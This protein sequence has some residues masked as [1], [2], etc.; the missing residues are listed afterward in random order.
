MT[1]INMHIIACTHTH[2]STH[3]PTYTYTHQL[4]YV[5]SKWLFFSLVCFVISLASLERICYISN[6]FI[7]KAHPWLK[8]KKA[9][10]RNHHLLWTIIFRHLP[11]CLAFV[12]WIHLPNKSVRGESR[13][14]F[15]RW[16]HGWDLHKEPLLAL[17]DALWTRKYILVQGLRA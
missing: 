14:P 4:Y 10:K 11:S 8:K 12:L 5:K 9:M 17:T 1:E 7:L 15:H 16:K 6:E 2:T 3:L 13:L